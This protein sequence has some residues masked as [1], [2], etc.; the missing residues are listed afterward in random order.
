SAEMSPSVVLENVQGCSAKCIRMLL[1]N[2]S[3][4]DVDDDFTVEMIPELNIAV[5]T[6]LKSIDTQEFVNKCAQNKRVTEF[7]MTA[8]LLEVTSSIKAE[9][10]PDNISTEYITVYF[11][12]ARN[13]GGPVSDV[14]LFPKENSAIIT[15]CDHKGNA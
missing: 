9:N 6:F 14:Q 4:L 5:A 10:I 3:G 2:I 1:E 15:F 13:G 11:E 8:R 12:S 7:N